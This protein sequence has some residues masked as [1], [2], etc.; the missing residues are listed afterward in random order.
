[1]DKKFDEKEKDKKGSTL[2]KNIKD[3][4][5]EGNEHEDGCVYIRLIQ[6]F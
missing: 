6:F 1:M 2:L 5:F 4:I 3:I